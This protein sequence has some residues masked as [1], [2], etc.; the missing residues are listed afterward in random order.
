MSSSIVS[1][2]SVTCSGIDDLPRW[3]RVCVKYVSSSIVFVLLSLTCSGFD[4][5]PMGWPRVCDNIVTSS[6]AFVLLS[7]T[8]SGFDELPMGGLGFVT[9]LCQV[10]PFSF[11]SV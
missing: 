5:L 4:E 2:Y 1:S 9:T 10:S 7:L 11:Y 3:P 8:C 6:I